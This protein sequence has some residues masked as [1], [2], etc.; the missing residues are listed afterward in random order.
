LRLRLVVK[1]TW[2]FYQ[3]LSW[4]HCEMS[5]VHLQ[6][7]WRYKV[8]CLQLQPWNW[9]QGCCKIISFI[10]LF[11]LRD[12]RASWQIGNIQQIHSIRLQKL[13]LI[14][15]VIVSCVSTAE[16]HHQVCSVSTVRVMM[17][18]LHFIIIVHRC[19]ELE[20]LQHSNSTP[21]LA[22]IRVRFEL[23]VHI[24]IQILAWT[25][26]RTWF[27]LGPECTV[28]RTAFSIQY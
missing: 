14:R 25:P 11:N 1:F 19:W 21:S 7:T 2:Y 23:R 8:I 10:F 28:L 22:W 27:W 6:Y 18:R 17:L 26:T 3:N 24:W 16:V 12:S 13:K 20:I 9:L 15:H 4:K 5:T